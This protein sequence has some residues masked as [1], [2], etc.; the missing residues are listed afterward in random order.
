MQEKNKEDSK[1]KIE[2]NYCGY[3][4]VLPTLNGYF[5]SQQT[6]Y[7]ADLLVNGLLW[8]IARQN[9]KGF[10]QP[11]KPYIYSILD[12]RVVLTSQAV[13]AL[14]ACGLPSSSPIISKSIKWLLTE[15]TN[16]KCFYFRIPTLFL[17]YSEYKDVIKHDMERMKTL[18]K[19]MEFSRTL[20]IL[21]CAYC[22]LC[23][24]EANSHEFSN[25]EENILHRL[26]GES[27]SITA[28]AATILA[29]IPSGKYRSLVDELIKIV[30]ATYRNEKVGGSFENSLSTTSYAI[31]DLHALGTLGY[32]I[33]QNKIND[34]IQWLQNI[35]NRK[36]NWPKDDHPAYKRSDEL[37]NTCL[38]L[39]ALAKACAKK[40][41]PLATMHT[42]AKIT[43][44][45][46]IKNFKRR[47]IIFPL[48]G[49]ICFV[50]IVFSFFKIPSIA[51]VLLIA[52]SA[53]SGLA[54]IINLLLYFFPYTLWRAKS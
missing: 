40:E 10:W 46:H 16:S 41:L 6:E 4:E 19:R 5:I 51:K 14:T 13:L 48:T 37:Y 32:N 30:D 28:Y 44:S 25:L 7:K 47:R 31:M 52:L 1:S 18:I 49:L 12:D 17:G 9:T 29:Q 15:G 2:S 54:S 33:P 27:A 21:T 42:M 3:T 50:L 45:R 34:S 22:L 24:E 23:A 53:I 35:Q 38:G 8:L 11:K 39:R 20:E 36:G 43:I 26:E